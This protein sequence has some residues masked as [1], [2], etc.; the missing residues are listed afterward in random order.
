MGVIE[1]QRTN[2]GSVSFVDGIADP[3]NQDYDTKQLYQ[4]V[5]VFNLGI[6]A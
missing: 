4:N 6:A 2:I 1:D 5:K 3:S